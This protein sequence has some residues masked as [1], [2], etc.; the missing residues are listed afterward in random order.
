MAVRRYDFDRFSLDP[1]ERRLFDGPALVEINSRYFD[2]LLLLL[3]HPGTLLSKE[4]FLQ[5]VWQGIPVTDEV[6]TQCIKTLRR[7]LGDSATQPHL[8]ET[9]PKHGYRFIAAVSCVADGD[10]GPNDQNRAP[11]P[12]AVAPSGAYDWRQ[13]WLT[14]GAGTTG[15]GVAGLLGGLAFGL[16]A[17]AQVQQ[18][19]TGALSALLVMV[20]VATLLA[21]IGAAGVTGGIAGARLVARNVTFAGLVGGALGGLLVGAFGQVIGHDAFLLLFGQAPGDITGGLEGLLLGAAVG[22]ADDLGRRFAADVSVRRGV[23]AAAGIG[24]LAGLLIAVTGGQL[25][26][27]SLAVL[28]GSFPDARLH[29][30]LLGPTAATVT[31]AL[32]GAWFSLC[33]A[34]ALMLAR[35]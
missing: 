15:G 31:N 26:G 7:Q 11:A 21:L 2:A 27:G 30:D 8:I 4:R 17:A 29:L 22:L 16:A 13:C 23:L 33:L 34:G 35:R 24:G 25:L 28:A 18:S 5:D 20:A 3:Q 9:I 14:L 6:L 19:G 10:P 1:V 32:E 12:L